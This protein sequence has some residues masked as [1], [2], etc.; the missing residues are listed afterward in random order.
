M[1]GAL[2]TLRNI[3]NVENEFLTMRFVALVAVNAKPLSTF[4]KYFSYKY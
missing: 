2:R 3:E 1:K 4:T